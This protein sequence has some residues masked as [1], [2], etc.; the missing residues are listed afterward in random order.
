VHSHAACKA[1]VKA[2]DVLTLQEMAGLYQDLQEVENRHMCIHGRPTI[3]KISKQ[4]IEKQFRR[5]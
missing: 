2:G 4:E 3:W 1:A 5:I